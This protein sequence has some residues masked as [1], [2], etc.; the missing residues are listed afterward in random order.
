MMDIE[1][2]NGRW[3]AA[4][5][6]KDVSTLLAFY[7]PDCIY[8]DNNTAGGIEGHA[9]LKP[10]LE[11]LFAATPAMTYEPETVWAIE[12][13]FCGRWYCTIDMPEGPQ[14]MRGFDLVILSGDQ[15]I[16]NEVYVHP[17]P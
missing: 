2:Y 12:G 8:K 10:Y 17:L 1:D 16:H 13:G 14:R 9:A 6:A 11:G 7:S 15:I 4:W 3:L 5:T